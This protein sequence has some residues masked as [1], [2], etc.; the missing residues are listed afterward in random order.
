[1]PQPV[2]FSNPQAVLP[3]KLKDTSIFYV[4]HQSLS[5]FVHPVSSSINIKIIKWVWLWGRRGYVARNVNPLL[6]LLDPP[7]EA[8]PNWRQGALVSFRNALG[9]QNRCLE[10]LLPITVTAVP[11]WEPEAVNM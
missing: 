9:T 6:I 8:S 5:S 4:T 2:V 1:M 10:A 7:L 11:R 3:W